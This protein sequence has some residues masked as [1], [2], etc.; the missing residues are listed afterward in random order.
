VTQLK[1]QHFSTFFN[2]QL[3]SYV[4]FTE[5]HFDKFLGSLGIVVN[6]K[7]S[8]FSFAEQHSYDNFHPLVGQTCKTR[9]ER[10][11]SSDNCFKAFASGL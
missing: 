11:V 3:K 9:L 4:K 10:C 2:K 5:S 1:A 6:V 7:R 8:W